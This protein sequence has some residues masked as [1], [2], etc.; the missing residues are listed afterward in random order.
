MMNIT[1]SKERGSCTLTINIKILIQK[2]SKA[3]KFIIILL[4]IYNKKRKLVINV[5][6]QL[7][8]GTLRLFSIA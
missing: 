1:S 4:I 6:R 3:K 2:F 7:L 8:I 5:T